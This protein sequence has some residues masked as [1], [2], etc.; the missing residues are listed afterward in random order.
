[1]THVLVTGSTGLLGNN[2]VRSLLARGDKVRCLVRPQHDPRP[3]AG[4]KVSTV[5]GDLSDM[6]SIYRAV[7]GV[8][9]VVHA[10]ADTHIGGRH[11]ERQF[12]VNVK[13][14]IGLA[15]AA[16][17]AA[18]RLV[19]VSSVDALPAGK[20]DQPAD[21]ATVGGAKVDCGYVHSKRVAE[22]ELEQLI[23][24]GLQAVIVNPGFML[25]PW[26][27]KP[28]SGRML[29]TV[30]QKFTPFGPS[31][32]ISVCDARDVADAIIAALAGAES[33][34][35]YILAGHNMR[36]I[37]AWRLFAKVADGR[38]PLCPAGPLMKIIAGRWGDLLAMLTGRE[39][40]VNS[41]AIRMSDLFHY[42]DSSRAIQELGYRLRPVEGTIADAWNWFREHGYCRG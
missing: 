6:K 34:K 9:H 11:R 37:E 36:Y 10:A 42:Y 3:L 8:S 21:E 27:W 2:V 31:G 4:L 28:S 25:G 1:M 17:Q 15:Q 12:A 20:R 29:L 24:Q 19:F 5:V 38:P 30:A 35:R 16:R 41:A 7:D 40:D 14:T 33:G 26:D 18:A 22:A 39:G 23:Q 32:G 13:G